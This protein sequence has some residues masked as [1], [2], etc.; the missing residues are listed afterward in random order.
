MTDIRKYPR[1]ASFTTERDWLEHAFYRQ[2]KAILGALAA[3]W[4]A[5]PLA[6]WGAVLGAIVG[7]VVG[8]IGVGALGH[9]AGSFVQ[10]Q[11]FGVIG[12]AICALAGMVIGFGFLYFYL[13]THRSSLR[14]R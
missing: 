3:A 4:T 6:I 9:F 12:A 14:V 1:P 5:L 2:D 11:G 8:L 7:A 10:N 13:V